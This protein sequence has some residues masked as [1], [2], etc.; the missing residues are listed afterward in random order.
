MFFWTFLD[1]SVWNFWAK[2]GR[3]EKNPSFSLVCLISFPCSLL[4]AFAQSFSSFDNKMLRFI[5]PCFVSMY[6]NSWTE[7]NW[8][9]NFEHLGHSTFSLRSSL[10]EPSETEVAFSFCSMINS[11]RNRLIFLSSISQ[12]RNRIECLSRGVLE[13]KGFQ[14][15]DKSVADSVGGSGHP[16]PFPNG[17]FLLLV[18]SW[19]LALT[20]SPFIIQL[21]GLFFLLC[22]AIVFC[23]LSNS[24][25]T[26]EMICFWQNPHD[27]HSP[28][29]RKAALSGQR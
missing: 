13:W 29:D 16:A 6:N 27:G 23:H 7:V 4:F 15:H 21:V 20:G 24:R 22:N 2:K 1:F 3:G 18:W 5:Q 28:S 17:C 10:L 8:S 9:Q 12:S 25:H 26:P 19:I 14:P 11:V